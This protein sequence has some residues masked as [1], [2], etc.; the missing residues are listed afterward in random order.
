MDMQTTVAE[1]SRH[2]APRPGYLA[3][4]TLGLPTHETI[5]A[6]QADLRAWQLG[7]V[8]PVAYGE[9]VEEARA[10]FARIARVDVGRVAIGSQ[11]SSQVAVVAA[12]VPDGAEVLCVTGDFSSVVFPFLAQ[13]HRGVRV[14]HVPADELAAAVSADTWL[15]AWSRVQSA[16]GAVS[17][18]DAILSAARA[19]GALTFCD[20]TQAAGVLPVDASRYDL[21]VTHS[22]KWLCSPRGAAFLTVAPEVHDRLVPVQAGWYAGDDVWESCYGPDM[23]LAADARAFDVSPAW[24]AWVGALPALRLFSS[25]DPADT[26]RHATGLGD[27]LCARLDREPQ[28]QAVVTWAD[29][30]GADLRVLGRAGLTVSGRAGRVRVAFHLWNTADD[31]DR[32]VAALRP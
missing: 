21:T 24:P 18:D 1:A 29:P 27:A 17:D 26:W 31:V 9:V 4:C 3:A 7:D 10:A 32:V 25:L 19:H 11:T 12:S 8:S 20:L 28:G 6:Q 30:D 13:A 23:N 22:Y 14:R 5:A 16:T 2:F 15:V